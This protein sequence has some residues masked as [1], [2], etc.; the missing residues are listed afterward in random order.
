MRYPLAVSVGVLGERTETFLKRHVV[1]L[2]PGR[3]MSVGTLVDS[4]R[5]DWEPPP[6]IL[7][8]GGFDTMAAVVREMQTAGVSVMLAEYLDESLPWIEA[9]RDSGIQLFAHAHGYDVSERL[10]DAAYRDRYLAYRDTAGVITMSEYSRAKLIALGL[11]ETKVFAIPYGVDV[12]EYFT[13]RSRASG[14]TVLAVGRMVGKKAPLLVLEAFRRAVAGEPGLRLDYVGDGPLLSAARQY[15]AVHHMTS[16]TLHGSVPNSR[17][18]ALMNAAD[19][20]VQHSITD[21]DT[22]NQEG[23]P[24]AILEAMAAGLPVVSTS[25]AGIPEAVRDTRTGFLVPE[26]DTAGMAEA[27]LTLVGS[28]ELRTSMGIAGWELAH[29]RFAWA[30]ERAGLLTVLGLRDFL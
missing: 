29:E 4:C 8:P 9:T 16:V 17:V 26:G 15:V 7:D 24:V 22:G 14:L 18:R 5:R 11:P 12:P 6:P 27:I 1:D 3:T 30:R 2:I 13:P 21:G 10:R 23:L 19:V 28:R 20:F 25:H